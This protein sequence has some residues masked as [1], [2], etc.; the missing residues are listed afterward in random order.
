MFFPFPPA[1]YLCRTYFYRFFSF[2]RFPLLSIISILN[3]LYPG[4]PTL[5]E[6]GIFL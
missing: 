2:E 5:A 3:A 6:E 4:F 1:A